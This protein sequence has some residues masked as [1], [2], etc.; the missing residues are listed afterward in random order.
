MKTKDLEM[1]GNIGKNY[2]VVYMRLKESIY[3]YS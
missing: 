3:I 2:R 1:P